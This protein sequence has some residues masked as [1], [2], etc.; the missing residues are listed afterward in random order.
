VG[1][2]S[3]IIDGVALG[4]SNGV[5]Q[6][7]G[8]N[9]AVA[10]SASSNA[11]TRG[12]FSVTDT[13]GDGSLSYNSSTGVFTYTGPSQAEANTRIDA[14]LSGGTG[15]TYTSGV[16]ATTITQ[17]TDTLARAA[18]S[19]TDTGGDGSL[20]YNNTTGVITY[21]GP[22]QSEANARIDARLSG[23]T[24]VTYA[25]GLISIGQAVGTTSEVSFAKI[26]TTSDVVVGGNLTVQGTQVILNT[27]TV[28][29]EDTIFRVNSGGATGANV[30]FEANVG[31]NIKQI[32]YTTANKWSIGAE[33]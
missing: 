14:R 2:N 6:F 9:V 16:I 31:G 5:L 23:G 13:G 17:Y 27:T 24:G 4:I 30:G 25:N 12:L 7:G 28:E 26:T 8:A 1:P 15:I 32:V 21:T 11:D 18:I 22:D 33:T 3:L 10:G 20:S 19:V 29:T